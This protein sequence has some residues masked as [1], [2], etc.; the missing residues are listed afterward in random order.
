MAEVVEFGGM[1][2][3]ARASVKSASVDSGIPEGVNAV[4]SSV[5]VPI[6]SGTLT[7]F[8]AESWIEG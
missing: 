7:K 6:N 4:P 2:V 1:A 8:P 3:E 5:F